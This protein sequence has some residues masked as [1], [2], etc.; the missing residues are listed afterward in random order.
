MDVPRDLQ[1][2]AI[3]RRGYDQIS[4]AY[5]DDLGTEK[6][7]YRGWLARYLLPRL[8]PSARVLD[9]GCG[10]GVPATQILAERHQVI[11][12]DISD[13][14]VGRARRLVPAA[15]FLR[16]D[17]ADLDYPSSSFEAIVSFFALIHIPVEEQPAIIQRIGRWLKPDGLFLA[18]VGHDALTR[19]GDFHGAR[20]YWS[21][22]DASTYCGWL[23]AA[24]IDV[25][26]REFIPEDPHGGHELLFGVRRDD[27]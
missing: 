7:G 4:T 26:D 14:Q 25:V 24:G 11:G 22:A 10:N 15:S 23:A 1:P 6:M 2:K 17:I 18:T 27:R 19:T 9:L 16:A 3:V 21:Q 20:M 8:A 12:V 13:V 5:R